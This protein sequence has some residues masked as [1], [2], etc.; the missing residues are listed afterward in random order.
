MSLD[1]SAPVGLAR[2]NRSADCQE[3]QLEMLGCPPDTSRSQ[4]VICRRDQKS[5]L[6]PAMVLN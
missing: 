6:P 1:N 3:Q 4:E 2:I 5:A